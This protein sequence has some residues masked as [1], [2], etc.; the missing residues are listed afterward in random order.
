[1]HSIFKY[2]NQLILNT[3]QYSEKWLHIEHNIIVYSDFLALKDFYTNYCKGTL[4]SNELI[5]L[6]SHYES[7]IKVFE[8]LKSNINFIE[9]YKADGSLVI[10][11][12]TKAYFDLKNDFVGI[13]IMMKMLLTRKSKLS[14]DGI[15]VISDMGNFFHP[16]NRIQDLFKHERQISSHASLPFKLY[17]SYNTYDL[18][19]LDGG[20]D[21]KLLRY[22]DRVIHIWC[23]ICRYINRVKWPYCNL[24]MRL[25]LIRY[26]LMRIRRVTKNKLFLIVR[27]LIFFYLSIKLKLG[28][29][30]ISMFSN[31]VV[32]TQL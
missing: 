4:P 32:L 30:W 22:H 3:G 10:V 24:P 6:L 20:Q 25:S 7:A 18:D 1:M 16:R 26:R 27:S 11:N 14:K 9:N 12:S 8:S 23:I 13:M 2:W 15:S 29:V 31:N 28:W 19:F 5:L 21:Q 17:C